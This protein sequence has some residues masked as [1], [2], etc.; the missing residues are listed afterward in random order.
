[1]LV[2]SVM[3]KYAPDT[4]TQ[5]RLPE[6]QRT[7]PDLVPPDQIVAAIMGTDIELPCLLAMWLSLSMSEIRGLTKSKSVRGSKLYIVETV[8]DVKGK[9]VRK[10]GGKEELRPRALDIPPHIKKLIDAVPDD[11]IEAR[12]GHAIYMRLQIVL[13]AAGLPYMRFHDLRH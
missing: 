11:I 1:M 3:H 2:A 6:I 10:V 8:V 9:P 4:E 12:S 13:K 7:F 5:V